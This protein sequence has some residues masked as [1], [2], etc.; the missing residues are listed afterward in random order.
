MT[1]K[2]TLVPVFADG[3]SVIDDAHQIPPGVNFPAGVVFADVEAGE[4]VAGDTPDVVMFT[5]DDPNT[6]KDSV[7]ASVPGFSGTIDPYVY[8]PPV[9]LQGF[10]IVVE[11]VQ[12]APP[13]TP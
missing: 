5:P 7:T 2:L 3:T 4:L 8:S 13:P 10:K 6:A 11:N 1:K 12:P 9:A